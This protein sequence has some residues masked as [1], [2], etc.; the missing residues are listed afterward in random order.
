MNL[1]KIDIAAPFRF[2][3][4]VSSG[5]GPHSHGFEQNLLSATH[6]RVKHRGHA[7]AR[8]QSFLL[9]IMTSWTYTRERAVKTTTNEE[10]IFSRYHKSTSCEF[11]G[12]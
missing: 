11:T 8:N 5:A 10:N 2:S 12:V 3:G 6:F 9:L 4:D 7:K 1:F